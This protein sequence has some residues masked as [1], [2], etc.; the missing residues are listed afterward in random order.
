MNTRFEMTTWQ[1]HWFESQMRAFG[2]AAE[3]V[4]KTLQ[5]IQTTLG[6]TDSKHIPEAFGGK[7][8]DVRPNESSRQ[9]GA[10]AES[11]MAELAYFSDQPEGRR[12]RLLLPYRQ[13]RVRPDVHLGRLL[14]SIESSSRRASLVR[15]HLAY[16][17]KEQPL[18]RSHCG[19]ESVADAYS[20][21]SDPRWRRLQPH[22]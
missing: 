7:K 16:S 11:E 9:H 6:A 3:E 14:R 21:L 13:P 1:A 19:R 8:D 18:L 12:M 15:A 20:L 4:K 2:Q 22:S 5:W 10:I 17:P